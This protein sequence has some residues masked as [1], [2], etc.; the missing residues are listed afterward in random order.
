MPVRKNAAGDSPAQARRGGA[1]G[2]QTALPQHTDRF[3]ACEEHR[4][5][6]VTVYVSKI[7]QVPRRYLRKNFRLSFASK[8]APDLPSVA[9]NL[10]W[11]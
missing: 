2:H 9:R 8:T 1:F 6:R 11:W 4:D 3:S 7:S 10:P 5:K